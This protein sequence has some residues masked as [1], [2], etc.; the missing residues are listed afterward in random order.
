MEATSSWTECMWDVPRV[1]KFVPRM[2]PCPPSLRHPK[3]EF[4]WNLLRSG[5]YPILDESIEVQEMA[6]KCRQDVEDV[7]TSYHSLAPILTVNPDELL[8]VERWCH[9][10][11]APV[12]RLPT[13]LLQEIFLC[14]LTDTYTRPNLQSAPLLL[15]QV[16]FSWRSLC[17]STPQL[18]SSIDLRDFRDSGSG[19]RSSLL[20]P[21]I[22]ETWLARSGPTCPLSIRLCSHHP[23]SRTLLP[24]A[25]SHRDRW[26]KIDLTFFARDA[27][28]FLALLPSQD[29]TPLLEQLDIH[30]S[31]PFE[32]LNPRAGFPPPSD[33]MSTLLQRLTSTR[34]TELNISGSY[35]YVLSLRE[36]I[37]MLSRCPNLVQCQLETKT[38]SEATSLLAR[39]RLNNLVSLELR[40]ESAEVAYLSLT[41]PRLQSLTVF[42]SQNPA[43]QP[44]IHLV[45]FL[46]RSTPPLEYLHLS[47]PPASEDH[48]VECLENTPR[49]KELSLTKMYPLQSPHLQCISDVMLSHLS[50]S[51]ST[52]GYMALTT[53]LYLLEVDGDLLCSPEGLT[54]MLIS[55]WRRNAPEECDMRPALG[56]E[57]APFAANI[58]GTNAS[59]PSPFKLV[60][61]SGTSYPLARVKELLTGVEHQFIQDGRTVTIS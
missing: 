23:E 61:H 28:F 33:H 20:P 17:L 15:C 37:E 51:S 29:P 31:L 6:V 5:R 24:I 1:R 30:F 46:A 56:T 58:S 42:T 49:L 40:A 12:R 35:A 44:H 50:A 26:R 11:L 38:I 3:R 55:R 34:L 52:G 41:L 47:P 36:G 7:I 53:H 2:L 48:L 16:C 9:S 27:E 14:C 43:I 10:A 57:A 45:S 4:V 59:G 21:T 25:L 19:L 13:D 39:V 22:V 18:W 8:H 60:V 54:G 32:S